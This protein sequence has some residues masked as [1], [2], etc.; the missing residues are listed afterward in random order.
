MNLVKNKCG[1]GEEG[2]QAM[3]SDCDA[4]L[5]FVLGAVACELER[6]H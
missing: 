6:D 2:Q 3:N 1:R 4:T 5:G